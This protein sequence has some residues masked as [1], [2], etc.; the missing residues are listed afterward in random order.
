MKRQ[1]HGRFQFRNRARLRSKPRR[2]ARA[3]PAI[4]TLLASGVALPQSAPRPEQLVKWRQSAYQFIGWN[5]G[6]IKSELAGVYD[7]AAV[8]AAANA[9]AGVAS[10]GLPS[11]FPPQTAGTKGWRAT[12]AGARVFSEAGE[13]RALSDVFAR[14]AG[15]LARLAGAGDRNAVGKQFARVAQACKTCHDKFRETE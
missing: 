7:A 1:A 11:L 12:T 2:R 3:L 10:S 6:R 4:L 8:Q 5:T 14:E 15:E 13:F 9:L